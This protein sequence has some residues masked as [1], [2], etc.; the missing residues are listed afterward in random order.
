[1][2]IYIQGFDGGIQFLFTIKMFKWD[3]EIFT[4]YQ[5]ATLSNQFKFVP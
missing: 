5:T 3:V 1:M 4:E 2:S